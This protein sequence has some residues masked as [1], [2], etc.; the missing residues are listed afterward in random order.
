[1]LYTWRWCSGDVLLLK[2]KP[3]R[4]EDLCLPVVLWI[5]LLWD[6]LS[7]CM[8]S[9][10]NHLV[11]LMICHDA[12]QTAATLKSRFLNA[13]RLGHFCYSKFN[14]TLSSELNIVHLD[15]FNSPSNFEIILLK[16]SVYV[17][18]YICCIHTHICVCVLHKTAPLN[19]SRVRT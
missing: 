9:A 7:A 3:I 19:S 15:E 8:R 14:T 6:K 10:C 1:M 5:L 4:R 16:H 12:N 13:L 2:K 17:Y 11:S 18:A